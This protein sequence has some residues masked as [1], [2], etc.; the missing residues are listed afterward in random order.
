MDNK[1]VYDERD[2]RVTE[3]I[4]I[5]F[6]NNDDNIEVMRVARPTRKTMPAYNY[7]EI[8]NIRKPVNLHVWPMHTS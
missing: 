8:V 1:D 7:L 2:S 5:C 6:Y 4:K 3:M